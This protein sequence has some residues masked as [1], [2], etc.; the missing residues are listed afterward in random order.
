MVR[1]QFNL[2]KEMCVWQHIGSL[3][4]FIR[5]FYNASLFFVF[6]NVFDLELCRKIRTD[7]FFSYLASLVQCNIFEE[8]TCNFLLVGHTG[9]EASINILLLSQPNN[10]HN[11]NNKTTISVV[12]LRQ[13]NCWEHYNPPTTQTQNYM[14]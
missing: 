9:N 6:M 14:K 7:L 11:P 2:C 5:F 10:N 13:S 8:A 3:C 4:L 1:L 12:G